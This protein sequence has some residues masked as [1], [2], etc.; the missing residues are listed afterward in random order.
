MQLGSQEHKAQFINNL[1]KEYYQAQWSD[2]LYLDLLTE[3]LGDKRKEI[4]A[5]ELKL[6]HKEFPSKND[7][8]K[9]Q[10]IAKQELEHIE[11][12]VAKIQDKLANY[13]PKRIASVTAY[14]KSQGIEIE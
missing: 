12:E 11:K 8:S 10:F 3:N 5:I 6:E 2:E 9:A 13:W 14:A 1:V 7:G 4:A